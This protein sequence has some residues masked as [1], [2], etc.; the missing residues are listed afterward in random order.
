MQDFVP[1][2]KNQP[3]AA[4]KLK[5]T[6]KDRGPEERVCSRPKGTVQCPPCVS[7]WLTITNPS[8]EAF[9]TFSPPVPVGVFAAKPRTGSMQLKKPDIWDPTS[10]SWTSRC[11]A[12]TGWRRRVTFCASFLI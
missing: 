11:L 9:E 7:Y 2:V 10:F 5:Y 3:P 4:V 6:C 1:R 8:A 12:W